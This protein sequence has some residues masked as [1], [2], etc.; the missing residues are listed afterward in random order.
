MIDDL[1]FG[2]PPEFFLTHPSMSK[3]AT[4]MAP[5]QHWSTLDPP[6]LLCPT[7]K[8]EFLNPIVS[9]R[10]DNIISKPPSFEKHLLNSTPPLNW[11]EPLLD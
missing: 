8:V 3:F 4:C 5:N 11:V 2:Y 7:S 1:M 9:F 10:I 6:L